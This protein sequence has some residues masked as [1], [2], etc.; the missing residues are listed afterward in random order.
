MLCPCDHLAVAGRAASAH[1]LNIRGH[2]TKAAEIRVRDGELRFELALRFGLLTHVLQG[3]SLSPIRLGHIQ[4]DGMMGCQQR[5]VSIFIR[6]GSVLCDP[7]H[8]NTAADTILLINLVALSI[9]LFI[10]KKN[11]TSSYKDPNTY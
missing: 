7:R 9:Y 6:D 4:Q 2:S 11:S 3:I 10:K 1:Y 8:P 5:S